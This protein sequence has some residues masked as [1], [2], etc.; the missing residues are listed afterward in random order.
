MSTRVEFA[1]EQPTVI[2]FVSS[3][4][5]LHPQPLCVILVQ[6]KINFRLFW[7]LLNIC[8]SAFLKFSTREQ[9]ADINQWIK[10][11]NFLKIRF[12]ITPSLI[13]K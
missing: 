12:S 3:R 6:L 8:L 9:A 10:A 5:P 11:R 13:W 7:M 1:P 4:D 2:D